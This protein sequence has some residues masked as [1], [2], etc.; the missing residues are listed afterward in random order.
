MQEQP[1]QSV[2]KIAMIEVSKDS[3]TVEV[4]QQVVVH[5][6]T[7]T[8]KKTKVKKTKVKEDKSERRQK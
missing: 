4:D 2:D 8:T 3:S 7:E 1:Q 6:S 5:N